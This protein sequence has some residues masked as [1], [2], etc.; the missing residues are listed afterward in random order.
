M[1]TGGTGFIINDLKGS[2]SALIRANVKAVLVANIELARGFPGDAG[3]APLAWNGSRKCVTCHTNG[4]YMVI[5]PA[6]SARVGAPNAA[7]VWGG[8]LPADCSGC[9]GGNA[10][11]AKVITTGNHSQ[12]I[13][14]ATVL[15]TNFG[16]LLTGSFLVQFLIAA[17]L[18]SGDEPI[19]AIALHELP[20]VETM[21]SVIH[22]GDMWDIGQ[23][24]VALY[25]WIGSHGYVSA[26]PYRELHLFWRELEIE[27][28]QFKNIVIEVQVPIALLDASR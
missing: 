8:T 20:A 14:N 19:V 5:R 12:H 15:G 2:V 26:G 16:A 25:A 23:A 13:S 6:L 3:G 18:R 7:A 17:E 22:K 10:T 4:T 1:V 9:H 11:A 28:E 27:A 21:A 24:M